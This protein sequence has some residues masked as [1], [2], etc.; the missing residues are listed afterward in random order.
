M[1]DFKLLK[2]TQ[3][4]EK[5]MA[6]MIYRLAMYLL[7]S[8]ALVFG[9]LAGIG[10][11]LILDSFTSSG[12][13]SGI[14]GTAGLAMTILILYWFRGT[15]FY[16]IKAPHIVLLNEAIGEAFVQQGL[17]QVA[18]ARSRVGERFCSS[19]HLYTLDN[20]IKAVLTYLFRR[21]TGAGKWLVRLEDTL[22]SRL[23]GRV[24][25]VP[26][27]YVH[28]VIIAECLK[29]LTRSASAVATT[30]L[31]L[32]AQNFD[33]LFKN[34][35]VLLAL[36]YLAAL[37]IFILMLAPIGWID[38]IIPV[39]FGNWTY[40]FALLFTWP[41]KSALFDP[42]ALAALMGVF[43]D[44]VRGQSIAPDWEAKLASDSPEFAS[45]KRQA[46]FLDRS[47][48]NPDDSGI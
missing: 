5:T 28:E 4:L 47:S 36:K 31:A 10:T 17:A 21:C 30:A 19:T 9:I 8:L 42:I 1:W 35:S 40:V 45:I 7:L 43:A 25:E 23:I 38:E 12:V 41:I 11:G 13:F 27:T 2:A 48:G 33:R 16:F 26:I 15:W 20:R 22:F 29:D 6:Y 24:L 37:V 46:E 39:E 18:H 3:T 14:G 32:Y 34:A 44:L